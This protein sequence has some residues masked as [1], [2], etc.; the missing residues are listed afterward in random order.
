MME[1]I[2]IGLT[3]FLGI[4]SVWSLAISADII[5]MIKV[6]KENRRQVDLSEKIM[7]VCLTLFGLFSLFVIFVHPGFIYQIPSA[8][9]VIEIAFFVILFHC[10]DKHLKDISQIKHDSNT[11]HYQQ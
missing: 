10:T 9:A 6:S 2:L 3:G 11:Q 8:V 7:L 5:R 4:M 1:M